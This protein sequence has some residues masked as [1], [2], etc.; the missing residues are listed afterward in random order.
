MSEIVWKRCI[1]AEFVSEAAMGTGAPGTRIT[2]GASPCSAGGGRARGLPAETSPP[3]RHGAAGSG[4]LPI[5]WLKL[6]SW[7]GR[8]WGRGAPGEPGRTLTKDL[9]GYGGGTRRFV[10]R[11][12]E[13]GGYG[14]RR[15]AVPRR[16]GLGG[17]LSWLDVL[18]ID[19]RKASLGSGHDGSRRI[20]G[21]DAPAVGSYLAG[22]S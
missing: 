12:T 21:Q 11:R 9:G 3:S 6:R 2:D 15:R 22:R 7:A 13:L 1:G 16:T 10:P 14:G 8:P 17:A 19:P 4:R 20:C 18:G 5:A